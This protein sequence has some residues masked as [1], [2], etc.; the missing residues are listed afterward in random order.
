MMVDS[1]ESVV[2]HLKPEHSRSVVGYDTLEVSPRDK[3]GNLYLDVIV[4]QFTKFVE[5][6]L[7]QE[8]TAVSTAPVFLR[9]W[10]I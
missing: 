9:L 7:K 2:R 1:L 8:K 3:F 6:Y 4:N 5:L 10:Y